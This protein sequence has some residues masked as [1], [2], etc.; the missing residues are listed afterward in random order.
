M[1]LKC[2]EKLVSPRHADNINTVEAEK[3]AESRKVSDT[4]SMTLMWQSLIFS[5]LQ[6]CSSHQLRTHDAIL[7]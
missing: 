6:L 4:M 1:I 3:K 7:I 2:P 5:S